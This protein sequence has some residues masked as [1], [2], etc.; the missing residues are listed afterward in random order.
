MDEFRSLADL[1]DLQSVDLDIDRLLFQR[2]HLPAL[3]AYKDAHAKAESLTKELTSV[4]A[5]LVEAT[6]GLDRAN[7]E[8]DLAGTKLHSEEN[9]LFAGGL[10]AREVQHLRQEVEMLKRKKTEEED[11]ILEL[12]ET[13]EDLEAKE[14]DLA[15]QEQAAVARRAEIE[16]EVSESW[17]QIDAEIAKKE[18]RKADIAPLIEEELMEL[19]DELRVSKDGVAVGRL[20]DGQCGGCHL[21]LTAA[22][23]SQVVKSDPPRCPHCRRILVP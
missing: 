13:K 2:Q 16:S 4:R 8:L 3:E 7:G 6:R 11:V 14:A 10:G 19:Y 1:L 23:Q 9:R 15:D 5:A 12:M 18:V 20:A 22:E 21:K 17:K